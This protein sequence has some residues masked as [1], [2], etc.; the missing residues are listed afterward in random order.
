MIKNGIHFGPGAFLK[1][2]R[3]DRK[4][5]PKVRVKKPSARELPLRHPN[6]KDEPLRHKDERMTDSFKKLGPSN[7]TLK[8]FCSGPEF[9]FDF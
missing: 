8:Q 6:A 1:N 4:A 5:R 9:Q 7:T 2:F 3:E